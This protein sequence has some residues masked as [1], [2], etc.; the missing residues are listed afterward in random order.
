MWEKIA[1]V[2]QARAIN[3]SGAQCKSKVNGMKKTYKSIKDSN[4]RSGS[5]RRTWTYF[6]LMDGIF[7]E[8]PWV[9]PV[10]TLESDAMPE[11][12]GLPS[13]T[14]NSRKRSRDD[15]VAALLE[16]LKENREERRVQHEERRRQHE[17]VIARQ[18]QYLAL[19]KRLAEK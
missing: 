1:S 9:A 14:Q 6:D 11:P 15:G 8:K 10:M 2:M 7:A 19:L 18:D 5:G 3:V 16:S 4:G 13:P 17:E 12:S